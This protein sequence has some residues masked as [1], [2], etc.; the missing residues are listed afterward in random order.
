MAEER[1]ATIIGGFEAE[2]RSLVK[3][4]AELKGEVRQMDKRLS[5]VE[6][7]ISD[8]RRDIRQVL[9]FV[10]GAILVPILLEI[11]KRMIH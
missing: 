2:V 10:I 8:V 1:G 11:G 9:F 6:A 7:A 3:D 4:V 5:N